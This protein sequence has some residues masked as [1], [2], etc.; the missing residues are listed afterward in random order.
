MLSQPSR[1]NAGEVLDGGTPA[2]GERAR[3]VDAT[4][5]TPGG[6]EKPSRT[7]APERG[8]REVR[9]RHFE[10]ETGHERMNSFRKERGTIG[11]GKAR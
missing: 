9:R 1:R 6:H 3:D 4:E 5:E 11:S 7:G 2:T 10:G 8:S